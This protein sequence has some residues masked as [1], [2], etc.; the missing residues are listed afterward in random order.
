MAL[1]QSLG[2]AN[3]GLDETAAYNGFRL[4]NDIVPGC[5]THD[6]CSARIHLCA[7]PCS[8]ATQAKTVYI[9][10]YL[11]RGNDG[12]EM[13]DMGAGGGSGDVYQQHEVE[14]PTE[15]NAQHLV[16]YCLECM[17]FY[18]ERQKATFEW[19]LLDDAKNNGGKISLSKYGILVDGDM[20][21]DDIAGLLVANVL[22]FDQNMTVEKRSNLRSRPRRTV[23]V[24]SSLSWANCEMTIPN[25]SHS[26]SP[27]HGILRTLSC[28][29]S[30]ASSNPWTFM[31]A[32]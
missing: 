7:P 24:S 16:R 15:M 17:D 5:L 27:T 31:L 20:S 12:F 23:I 30:F 28:V 2:Q 32:W 9:K 18:S 26:A 1:Y 21:L 4:G 13:R 29:I 8:I 22:D 14:F 19:R 25:P 11:G 10:P 6:I 3:R